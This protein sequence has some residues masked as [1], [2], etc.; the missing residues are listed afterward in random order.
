GKK[1]AND[2]SL[3]QLNTQL[4]GLANFGVNID[5]QTLI[6]GAITNGTLLIG[7][8]V[9]AKKLD[10]D[11]NPTLV[12]YLAA[13][14]D[15]TAIPAFDGTD[16]IV[17][18]GDGTQFTFNSPVIANGS[19]TTAQ[20]DFVFALPLDPNNPTAL[21]LHNA[22]ITGTID[23]TNLKLTGGT[24]SGTVSTTDF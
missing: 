7:A 11:K 14:S 16:T 13:L 10:N 21:T 20:S 1:D 18:G 24:L 12:A 15:S 5:L 9:T 19:L 23:A 4:K 22:E 3:E 6:S 2:N 8:D 17:V